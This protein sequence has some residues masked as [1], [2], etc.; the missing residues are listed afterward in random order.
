MAVVRKHIH[1]HISV[2]R[3]LRHRI[4]LRLRCR[5][6][7]IRH[8]I[9]RYCPPLIVHHGN[10]DGIENGL[11]IALT[12][13][14]PT[15]GNIP[16]A[17]FTS[18]GVIAIDDQKTTIGIDFD[19]HRCRSLQI[20]QR[21]RTGSCI[22]RGSS[23]TTRTRFTGKIEDQRLK[24]TRSAEAEGAHDTCFGIRLGNGEIARHRHRRL[25][26]TARN[27]VYIRDIDRRPGRNRRGSIIRRGG[28]P[29]QLHKFR[30]FHARA[31]IGQ[32]QG[33]SGFEHARQTGEIKPAAF[34]AEQHRGGRVQDLEGV[35]ARLQRGQH[36]A[37]DVGGGRGHRVLGRLRLRRGDV[38][39]DH[40][41]GILTNNH[42][43][44]AI[45]LQR[46][47]RA[48]LRQDVGVGRHTHP[49]AQGD[50]RAVGCAHPGFANDMRNQNGIGRHIYALLR[51]TSQQLLPMQRYAFSNI[52][53][54][55]DSN[56]TDT[57]NIALLA[58]P[59][60]HRVN[61]RFPC[62]TSTKS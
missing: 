13:V 34:A 20:A 21:Y 12:M 22:S 57:C 19:R 31:R 58:V 43:R 37:G 36:L 17:D 52:Y 40:H 14:L 2:L 51:T 24:T 30:R 11:A 10:S 50:E 55:N 5:V 59:P 49:F 23:A 62:V 45:G 54:L 4:V 27:I 16:I 46:H 25:L 28:N 33:R 41:V 8:Q 42:R 47:G 7:D 53:D 29:A 18:L 1:C 39:G 9:R 3:R 35:F 48:F 56:L 60:Y 38:V 32:A 6:R 61:T 44:R 15:I 26:V